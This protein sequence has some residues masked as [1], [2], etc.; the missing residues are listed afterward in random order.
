MKIAIFAGPT[1][2]HFFPALAFSEAFRKRH[3]DARILVVTGLRGRGL[4]EKSRDSGIAEFQFL[5]DFPF[6]RRWKR[7]YA[8]LFSG[9]LLKLAQAFGKTIRIMHSFRPN[10]CVGF[11]SYVSFPGI[12]L[13]HWKNIP[14]LIHEQNRKAGQANVWLRR[15]ANRIAVSFEGTEDLSTSAKISCT[16][17]PLR[18]SLIE[19]ARG[20]KR[21]EP[22]RFS[23]GRV[24]ILALGGSQG[25]EFLN[26]LLTKTF[27]LLCR[28]EKSKVAVIHITGKEDFGA[29]E[30][31][32]LTK[33]M[34][35]WVLAFHEKMEEIYPEADLAVTR[36]GAN[37]LFELALFGLPAIVIPYPHAERHQEANARSFERAGGVIRI[38]Q[39][40]A[41]PAL[42]KEKI[43]Q[44][45]NSEETRKRMSGNLQRIANPRA[46]DRLVTLAESLMGERP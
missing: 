11:G 13:G 26:R 34:E 14:T 4:V 2:G 5:P 15:A 40:E 18:S 16:G 37:T 21:A 46:S 25:S 30:Q 12:L 23:P 35:A 43:F 28:E 10:L 31:M 20:K 9:F 29:V 8:F 3:P 6:P 22:S 27:D 24:R 33:G 45:L 41:H 44:L 42:L 32:Y 17:L 36:A 7:D 1:G 38:P 19:A 39:N